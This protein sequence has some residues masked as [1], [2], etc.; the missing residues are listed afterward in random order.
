MCTPPEIAS[1]TGHK[2]DTV[3]LPRDSVMAANAI[4]KLDRWRSERS[5]RRK[6]KEAEK[7]A[8]AEDRPSVGARRHPRN[9]YGTPLER[10][11]ERR[12]K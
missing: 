8:K 1:I 7:Q 10:A 9:R 12:L 4:A 11:T 6:Q 5:K 2:L 3:Y